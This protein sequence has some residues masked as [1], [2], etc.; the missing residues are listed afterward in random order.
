[1]GCRHLKSTLPS[2]P[3][4]IRCS[5]PCQEAFEGCSFR[6]DQS[7]PDGSRLLWPWSE[8]SD[9][10]SARPSTTSDTPPRNPP[11]LPPACG[12]VQPIFSQ[13][14]LFANSPAPPQA[15]AHTDTCNPPGF[16]SSSSSFFMGFLSEKP[17]P[18]LPEPPKRFK[19]GGNKAG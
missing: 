17:P 3:P 4:G 16:A 13:Q 11:S 9:T 18:P 10:R 15:G 2:N 7:N 12:P 1:M 5:P 14:T 6:L 19:R 8:P